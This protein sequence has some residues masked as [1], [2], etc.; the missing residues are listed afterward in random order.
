MKT[1]SRR[2]I[3]HAYHVL[4]N[5]VTIDEI[6]FVHFAEWVR[7][8]PRLGEQWLFSLAKMWRKFNPVLLHAETLKLHTP[9]VIGVLLDQCEKYLILKQDKKFFNAWKKIVLFQV[10]PARGESFLIGIHGFA[11][12]LL[13]EE[14]QFASQAYQRWGFGGKD[15][16]INKFSQKQTNLQKSDLSPEVRLI[17]LKELLK[18]KKRI[19]VNDYL[20]ACDLRISKRVA[21]KDLVLYSGLEAHGNSRARFFTSK[22]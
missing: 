2:E 20:L 10:K 6:A 18:K 15:V 9:A 8:D 7:F 14:V 17:I 5:S 19:T 21:Q 3:E 13:L 22:S 4:F 11:T 12:L 16:F 1:P